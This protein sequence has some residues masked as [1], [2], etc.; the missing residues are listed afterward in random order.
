MLVMRIVYIVRYPVVKVT[1]TNGFVTICNLPCS[2]GASGVCREELITLPPLCFKN[3]KKVLI[4][5]K[6]TWSYYTT[7]ITKLIIYKYSV[8]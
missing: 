1:I 2:I 8:V 5:Q 7:Q 6:Y 4:I 3:L